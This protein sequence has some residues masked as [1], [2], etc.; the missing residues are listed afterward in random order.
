MPCVLLSQFIKTCR[1]SIRGEVTIV[2]PAKTDKDI[3]GLTGKKAVA[4]GASVCVG[5]PITGSL[6]RMSS[7][8]MEVKTSG[9]KRFFLRFNSN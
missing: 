4:T 6:P 5:I 7:P 1:L 2:E 8:F 9:W 3:F